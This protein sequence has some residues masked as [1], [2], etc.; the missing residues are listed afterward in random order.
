MVNGQANTSRAELAFPSAID[1]KSHL[2]HRLIEA[3]AERDR[4]TYTAQALL[5]EIEEIESTLRRVQSELDNDQPALA[6]TPTA[7]NR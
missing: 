4:A 5:V 3:V 6:N 2:G 1:E 7:P